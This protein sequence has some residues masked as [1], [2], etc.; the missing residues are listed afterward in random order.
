MR[1]SYKN[2]KIRTKFRIAKRKKILGRR[3]NFGRRNSK[4]IDMGALMLN[5]IKKESRSRQICRKRNPQIVLRN[6]GKKSKQLPR[7]IHINRRNQR[8]KTPR[9]ANGFVSRNIRI[10]RP[11]K[12]KQNFIISKK[13]NAKNRIR[14][15]SMGILHSKANKKNIFAN[16]RKFENKRKKIQISISPNY[17]KNGQGNA[18]MKNISVGMEKSQNLHLSN[19]EQSLPSSTLSSKSS[20]LKLEDI[21]QSSE[22]K[23]KKIF[24]GKLGLG[25]TSGIDFSHTPR[26]HTLALKMLE[27]VSKKKSYHWKSQKYSNKDDHIGEKKAIGMMCK[28]LE[29]GLT[30]YIFEEVHGEENHGKKFPNESL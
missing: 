24:Q 3:K 10:P 19:E 22:G 25:F 18:S 6:L 13:L 23:K 17:L 5:S 7:P 20:S 2:L 28:L 1:R 12:K 29:D 21:L 16:S 11:Q 27:S 26:P 15:R 9:I 30:R 14:N 4:S 8:F